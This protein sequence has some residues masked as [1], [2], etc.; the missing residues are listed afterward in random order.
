[1]ALDMSDCLN[2]NRMDYNFNSFY[3]SWTI[4]NSAVNLLG[5]GIAVVTQSNV[6]WIIGVNMMMACFLINM[7]VFLP[8][9]PLVL[10]YA[11]WVTLLRFFIIMSLLAFHS[12]LMNGLILALFFVAICLDGIDG[13]L[14]RRFDQASDAGEKFDVEVD[15]FLVFALSWIHVSQ[16]QMHWFVLI[17]GGLKYLYELSLFWLPNNKP[18]ILPKRIRSTIAVFFFFSLLIPFLTQESYAVG[19]TYF[20]GTIIICSFLISFYSQFKKSE[21]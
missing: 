10:G 1:M 12:Y 20:A 19:V 9:L 6:V 15:A 11:N 16:Y 14:A 2:T 17:P 8:K 21:N 13:Y 18:E 5:L 7:R 4:I 3:K